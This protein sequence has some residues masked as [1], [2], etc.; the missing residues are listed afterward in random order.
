MNV[1]II[2]DVLLV[3]NLLVLIFVLWLKKFNPAIKL[4]NPNLVIESGLL[5]T[6]TILV[7]LIPK[8]GQEKYCY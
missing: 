4:L 3:K 1:M 7:K 6:K 8:I 5:S 2:K